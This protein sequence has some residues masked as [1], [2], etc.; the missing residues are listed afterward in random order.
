[1]GKG[2]TLL[3]SWIYIGSHHF[4]LV[5]RRAR[6]LHLLNLTFNWGKKKKRIK[7]DEDI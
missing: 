2:Q 6:V 1:M 3:S 5:S 4:R 7:A